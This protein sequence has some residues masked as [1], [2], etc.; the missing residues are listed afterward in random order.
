MPGNIVINLASG[1]TRG[2]IT[3]DVM[4]H[5]IQLRFPE[6]ST[7]ADEEPELAR[8]TRTALIEKHADTG[9]LILPAHF[10][11]PSVGHIETAPA[12]GFRFVY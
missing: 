3:G 8:V 2:V 9:N 5:Q 11:A 12:G 10:P 4:H 6:L 1:G 7:Y